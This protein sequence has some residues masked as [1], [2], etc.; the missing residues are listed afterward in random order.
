[1]TR[2]PAVFRITGLARSVDPRIAAVV[3]TLDMYA[4]HER[5]DVEFFPRVVALH[6]E[7]GAELDVPR[8]L[9]LLAEVAWDV[10][11]ARTGSDR[12]DTYRVEIRPAVGVYDVTALDADEQVPA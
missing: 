7:A 9:D 8:R 3:V 1:M 11:E 2:A 6:D 4:D 12:G 5:D 10:V